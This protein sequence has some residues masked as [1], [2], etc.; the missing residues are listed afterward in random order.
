MFVHE[1]GDLVTWVS[2]LV[3]LGLAVGIALVPELRRVWN[4]RKR[5]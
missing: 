2:T 1:H 3:S 4:R 5:R